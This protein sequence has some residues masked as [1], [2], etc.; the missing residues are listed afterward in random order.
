M[1]IV[2]KYLPEASSPE[3]EKVKKELQA[4]RKA[5]KLNKAGKKREE[6]LISNLVRLG[7]FSEV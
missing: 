7:D 5:G 3:I 6:Q 1:D 4:L 2:D